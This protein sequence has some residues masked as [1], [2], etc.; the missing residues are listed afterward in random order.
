MEQVSSL[1]IQTLETIA[2]VPGM[3]PIYRSKRKAISA[4]FPYAVRLA[5][6]DGQWEMIN[7]ILR[8]AP[9]SKSGGFMWHR[10]GPYITT[11]SDS[12]SPTSLDMAIT[13][14]SPC[15]DWVNGP[16]TENAVARWAAAALTTT[17]SEE[18]CRSAV[19]ALLKIA[20]ND[21]L[22][23]HVPIE[24]WA[25]LKRRPSLPPVCRGQTRRATPGIVRHIRGLGDIEI[26]KSYFL[27]VWS[28]WDIPYDDD[29]DDITATENTIRQEF[30][31]FQMRRH[32]E[33]LKGRL[34]H[35]REQLDQGLEHFK[36]CQPWIEEN[37]IGRM[38]KRYGKLKEV[39]LEADGV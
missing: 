6:D 7:A 23:P 5:Q 33:D 38:K 27:L 10:I 32:R 34:D 35:I 17:Y 14:A 26:L 11:L 1:I 37:D 20:R 12:L 15:A 31:G 9:K 3:T 18:V 8:F 30:C 29:D 24:I 28:E 25:W 2:E 16:Y 36:Q 13:L 19:D 22:R 4:L 21:S 39:L